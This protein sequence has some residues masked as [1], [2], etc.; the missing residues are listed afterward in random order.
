MELRIIDNK[1]EWDEP[2]LIRK[3]SQFLQSWDWGVFQQMIGRDVVR[4][5]AYDGEIP[6]VSMQAI[7]HSLPLG[8]AY[9]YVPRGPYLHQTGVVSEWF[10]GSALQTL[11]DQYGETMFVRI[12]PLMKGM[13][14][15]VSIP[16]V[17]PAHE[18]AIKL[19]LGEQELL[20]AMREKTRYNV[21]LATRKG[22]TV[23][24]IEQVEYALRAFPKV[25]TLLQSTAKRQGIH[26]HAKEYYEVMLQTLLPT[27]QA[28][29]FVAEY[30]K[31]IIAAHITIG[32]GDTLYYAHGASSS[33]ERQLMAPHLLHWTAMQYGKERSFNYYNFGGV[34]PLGSENHKWQSLTHFKQGFGDVETI[35]RIN[36]PKAVDIVQHPK[37]YWVYNQIK[38]WRT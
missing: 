15:G 9:W 27:G 5:R 26:T 31:R 3:H 7:L 20:D 29:L 34:S 25:W 2:L 6:V 21:R 22:V 18:L 12:E 19:Y 38:R 17:Q 33:A 14:S 35:E 10:L 37:W 30:E 4:M 8:Q 36:Y 11:H 13:V 32:F 1:V 28:Q 24:R 16:T 23:R